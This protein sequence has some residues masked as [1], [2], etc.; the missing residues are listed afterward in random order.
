MLSPATTAPAP[1]T[2]W[3]ITIQNVRNNTRDDRGEN[4]SIHKQNIRLDWVVGLV[5]VNVGHLS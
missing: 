5:L 4:I 3:L 1:T 2:R